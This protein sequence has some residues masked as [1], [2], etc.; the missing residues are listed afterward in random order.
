MPRAK[1]PPVHSLCRPDQAF[2]L[3]SRAG[4]FTLLQKIG[5][6]PK[7]LKMTT[8]FHEDMKGT[9][10]YD[11]SSSD[12]FPIK[13]GVKQGCVLAPTLFGILFSLLLC[14]AFSQSEEGIYLRTR[15]DSS[16]LNHARLRAKTKVRKVIICEMLFADDAALKAHTETALQELISC[17]AH[18]CTEFGLT[19][20]I[21]K[22]NV[23]GQDASSAPRISIGD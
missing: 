11:G 14:Y 7:L 23:L 17:F 13:S 9:V 12:P 15:N 8:S 1:T 18:A 4:L 5:C 20:S 10:Q 16:L 3:V 22:T 2:D 21:K 19:I 6:P